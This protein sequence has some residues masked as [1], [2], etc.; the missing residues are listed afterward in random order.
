MEHQQTDYTA[1]RNNMVDGQIRPNRVTDPRLLAALRTLP[2]E[3]FV[4]SSLAPLAYSDKDVPLGNGR[5]LMEPL[6]I[7]R[8]VQIARVRAGDKVLV[9][10]SGTG[11][12]AALMDACEAQVTALEEDD[13]LI[14]IALRI[15]P[16]LAPAVRL[17]DGRL[18]AGLPGGGPWNVVMIEGAVTAIP[19][20][21]AAQV[22][23]GGRLVTVLA[24]AGVPGGHATL[25]E[26]V[27][28]TGVLR[29][30]T[31][32]DCSTAL[33]PSLRPEPV[34]VF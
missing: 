18:S 3:L 7:A 6:I 21:L 1:A 34:F 8:L 2:R 9:V 33:L 5:V 32:F 17:V 28:S 4:P 23:P 11:Y 10:A 13:A 24:Q 29:S 30:R 26:P 31:M 19:A 15:L 20:S 12:G 27:G 16:R 22:A 14:A 25:A